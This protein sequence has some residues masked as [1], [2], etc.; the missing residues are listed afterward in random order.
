MGDAPDMIHA[1][2]T[3]ELK[4]RAGSITESENQA[5]HNGTTLV[6]A[7]RLLY[8]RAGY[9]DVKGADRRNTITPN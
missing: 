7:R 5:I 9:K 2:L 8:Q 1:F 6:R 4:G 3:F